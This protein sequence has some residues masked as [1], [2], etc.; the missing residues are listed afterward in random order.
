MLA[1]NFAHVVRVG[2]LRA[3]PVPIPGAEA[4]LNATGRL[5]AEAHVR[6][7]VQDARFRKQ[8][9]YVSHGGPHY[10]RWVAVAGRVIVEGVAELCF[11]D[12]RGRE[13]LGELNQMART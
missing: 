10:L 9:G 12:Q 2:P 6:S 5:A 1:P 13:H 11:I 8:V 7:D 3:T 4:E